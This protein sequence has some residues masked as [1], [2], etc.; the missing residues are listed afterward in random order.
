MR[1]AGYILVCLGFVLYFV[2][3]G[4][5]ASERL[6]IQVGCDAKW[7]GERETIPRGE[8]LRHLGE[9]NRMWSRS[10]SGSI[11]LVLLIVA[12]AVLLDASAVRRRRE[13]PH[14]DAE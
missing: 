8:V 13:K 3:F 11:W 1:I 2:W 4:V 9:T 10:Q 6:A 12:G 14:A 7:L 5:G